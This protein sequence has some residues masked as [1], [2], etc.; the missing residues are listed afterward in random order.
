MWKKSKEN[1]Q[2]RPAISSIFPAFSAEK[3][4][5][6]KI[7]LD[8]VLSIAK[9]HLSAKSQKKIMTESWGN[10]KKLVFPAY[11]RHFW[12][13]KNFSQKL[14][15]AIFWALLIR[16]FVQKIRKNKRWNLE[17]ML[18]NRF[19]RHISGTFGR[20]KKFFENR[21]PS[22]FRYCHF[23]SLYKISWKNIKYSSRTPRNTV[24]P[25]I[26]RK[27]RLQKSVLLTI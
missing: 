18:K 9:T 11:F 1:L 23:A 5:F 19:F 26:F 12:P 8:H 17:K 3:K 22:Y 13:E 25:A 27:F 10:V 4:F 15:L 24:L 2:K 21:S 14:D 16:V 7:G 6:T 20:K